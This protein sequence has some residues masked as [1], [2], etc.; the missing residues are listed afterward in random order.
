MHGLIVHNERH[1]GHM[2]AERL[3]ISASHV[4]ICWRHDGHKKRVAWGS[5]QFRNAV[6]V[7]FKRLEAGRCPPVR[8]LRQQP[9]GMRP[10]LA[11]ERP[12]RP[13][14]LVDGLLEPRSVIVI[15]R[16]RPLNRSVSP[17]F[18]VDRA[19]WSQ[20]PPPEQL[21][22]KIRRAKSE[23]AHGIPNARQARPCSAIRIHFPLNPRAGPLWAAC[24]PD[25]EPVRTET[26]DRFPR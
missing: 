13:A 24:P 21:L 5:M 25:E 1:R 23:C 4:S 14:H 12:A 15:D 8:M 17:S 9:C 19:A 20:V 6:Q 26:P 16:Q 3:P 7:G 22:H 2:T 10:L 11:H 18:T